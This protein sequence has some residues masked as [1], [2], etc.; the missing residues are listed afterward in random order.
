VWSNRIV[1]YSI[2]SRL[3]SLLAVTAFNAAAAR[4]GDLAGCVLHTDRGRNFDH[5]SS[6]WP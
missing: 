6:C 4:R 5:E 3:K 2:D 1:G